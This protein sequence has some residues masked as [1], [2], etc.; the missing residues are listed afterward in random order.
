MSHTVCERMPMLNAA[1][2]AP[3]TIIRP[4]AAVGAGPS[5]RS[6]SGAGAC[7][8]NASTRHACATMANASP[9]RSLIGRTARYQNNGH[10]TVMAVAAKAPMSSVVHGV[11]SASARVFK[12][13]NTP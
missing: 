3:I 5:R 6:P 4:D 9:G 11:D 10:D 2:S 8:Q 7:H 12:H 13:A 1:S